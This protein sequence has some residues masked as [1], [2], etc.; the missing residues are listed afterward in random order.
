MK[1]LKDAAETINKYPEVKGVCYFNFADTP[2]AW[3][4][5]E[6]PDWS[7]TPS[8]LKNFTSLLSDLPKNNAQ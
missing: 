1:W 4:N 5:A 3:G 2:K 6:T 7:I 8:T